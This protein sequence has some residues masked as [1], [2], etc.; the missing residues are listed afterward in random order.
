[1][2]T[3]TRIRNVV[4]DFGGVL[5][6]WQPERILAEVFPEPGQRDA[7]RRDVFQH[8]DW[9]EF[10][11]GRLPEDE[12][13]RRFAAR[14]ALEEDQM[15]ALFVAIRH[16]L[17]PK[18]DTIAVLRGLAA[19]RVPLYALSN[20]TTDVFGWLAARHDFFTLFNGIVVSGAVG[21]VKP[22]PEIYAHL[23][24]TH[25]IDPAESLFIDDMEANVAAARAAGYE[26][27]RF[28]AAE[29]LAA[30]LARRGL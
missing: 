30:E 11:R 2:W 21:L 7:V 23:A 25:R 3:V 15:R 20:M 4:F 1:V 10:D 8:P 27:L 14:A 12:A 17:R 24:A 22:E 9:V 28:T 26:A 6:E 19:R 13:V 16:A 29:A 18:A 5:V